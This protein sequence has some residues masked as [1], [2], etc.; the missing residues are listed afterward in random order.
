M[1]LSPRKH[2]QKSA[3]VSQPIRGS[4]LIVWR[5]LRSVA[6]MTSPPTTQ[7]Q[8]SRREV[9]DGSGIGSLNTVDG[10]I[11]TLEAYG[12][13][14]RYPEVGSNDGYQYELLTLDEN[15]TPVISIRTIAAA[16]RQ[17]ADNLERNDP[18]IRSEQ[19]NQWAIL[20]YK[21]RK[22]LPTNVYFRFNDRDNI[23]P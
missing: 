6:H 5:Y 12:L 15:P 11:E 3:T 14:S 10:A 20:A 18:V 13:L 2:S 8:V 4:A 22:L 9:K 19:L 16:L 1:N 23:S 21:A 7:F 17:V